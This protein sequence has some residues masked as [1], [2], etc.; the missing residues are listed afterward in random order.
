MC[1][2]GRKAEGGRER[3][4]ESQHGAQHR[5][6]SHELEISTWAKIKNWMLNWLS[7]PC[8]LKPLLLQIFFK[9]L[10]TF[11]RERDRTWVGEGWRKGNTESEADSR[12]PAQSPTPG[13]N[14]RTARSWP[15]CNRVL[16]WLS[17][18]GAPTILAFNVASL[19][20]YLFS[21]WNSDSVLLVFSITAIT[22]RSTSYF[23]LCIFFSHSFSPQRLGSP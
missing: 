23:L 22:M 13:L 5:A 18:P 4:R 21:L 1:K 14:P 12:L 15:E 9:C 2:W 8:A 3:E 19:L 10:F 16:N 11:E 6:Q 7:H 20:F 17:H